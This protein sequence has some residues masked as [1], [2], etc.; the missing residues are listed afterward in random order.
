MFSKFRTVVLNILAGSKMPI[1]AACLAVILVSG[2]IGNGLILDDYQH[3]NMLL[4]PARYAGDYSPIAVLFVF[5][6]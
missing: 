6:P 5:I 3:R 2:S 1:I 4:N